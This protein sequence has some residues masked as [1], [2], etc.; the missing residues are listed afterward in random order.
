MPADPAE[1]RPVTRAAQRPT[2]LVL[3]AA[4][5]TESVLLVLHGGRSHSDQPTSPYQLAYRRMVPLARAAHRGLRAEGTAVWLLRNRLRG[6]NEP[7]QDPVRDARWALRCL[8][9]HHPT[10]RVVLVGH[11]MGGRTAL[12]LADTPGVV[13]VCALA[14]WIEPDEPVGQLAGR[15]VLIAHGDRDRWTSPTRSFEYARRARQVTDRICRFEVPGSGHSML[16][17]YADWTGLVR[18]FAAGVIGTEPPHPAILAAVHA[19]DDRG[20]RQALPAGGW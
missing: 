18:A 1:T 14:P 13:G 7:T 6:W 20:L 9:R 19:L 3:P 4:G 8:H 2:V 10:A 12:R 15:S 5:A 16:R 17:R 11:S